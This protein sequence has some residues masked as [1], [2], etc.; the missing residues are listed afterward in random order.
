M[1]ALDVREHWVGPKCLYDTESHTTKQYK[2]NTCIYTPS[3]GFARERELKGKV[4]KEKPKDHL[5]LWIV[6]KTNVDKG[7]KSGKT[8]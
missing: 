3:D 7:P 2:K 8:E 4:E 1:Q 6:C 5:T